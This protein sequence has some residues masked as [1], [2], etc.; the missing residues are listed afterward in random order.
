M[1]GSTPVMSTVKGAVQ[2]MVMWE[3]L[4]RAASTS[5]GE[6]ST[7]AP[8]RNRTSAHESKGSIQNSHQFVTPDL[9]SSRG[10]CLIL[11]L[12]C[13]PL[14]LNLWNSFPPSLHSCDSEIT[15]KHALLRILTVC[16][17]AL[18]SPLSLFFPLKHNS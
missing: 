7:P 5:V 4:K 2:E 6:S 18:Y 11:M 17:I 14:P 16:L 8:K 10:P 3:S 9:F 13:F 15:F 1:S 12:T